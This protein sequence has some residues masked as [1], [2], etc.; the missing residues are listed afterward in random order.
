MRY[1]IARYNEN[2]RELA[3]RIYVTDCLRITARYTAAFGQVDLDFDRFA[4]RLYPQPVDNRTA[5]D[6][7]E[8]IRKKL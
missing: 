6:I 3:Y 2:Q 7:I 1:A 4:D 5:D 8:G